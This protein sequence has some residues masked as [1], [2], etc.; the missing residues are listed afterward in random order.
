VVTRAIVLAGGRGTR[1]QPFTFAFPKP[2]MPLGE[3]PILDIILRQ[4]RAAGIG[5]VTIAVGYLA[6]LIMAY[7]A[8]ATPDGLVIDYSREPVPLGTAGPLALVEPPTEPF[9]VM[10]GD[11]LTTLDYQDLARFH[12]ASGA[13]ATIA[14][15]RKPVHME[16]GVLEVD[17]DDRLVRYVEKPTH[18]FRVSMGVYIFE[19]DVLRHIPRG[20]RLDLPELVNGLVAAGAPLAVYPFA[21]R[22]LDIGSAEDYA[23]ALDDFQRQREQFLPSPGTVAAGTVEG[24]S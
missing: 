22:W 12:A 23:T 17:G 24:Q 20:E 5:R 18:E 4:L 7:F 9:L 11:I 10:N 2:L 6:E 13:V 21:G 15:F 3:T 16:L 14:A 8:N 1:L 19:P